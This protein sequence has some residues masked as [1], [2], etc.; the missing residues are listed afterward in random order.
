M[1]TCHNEFVV[2][3]LSDAR[4]KFVKS[5]VH[6]ESREEFEDY[7]RVLENRFYQ[8]VKLP[9]SPYVDANLKEGNAL[10]IYP[11]HGFGSGLEGTAKQG[12]R[13]AETFVDKLLDLD[14]KRRGMAVEKRGTPGKEQPR[15]SLN[16]SGAPGQYASPNYT[17]LNDV[18]P[19]FEASGNHSKLPAQSSNNVY[20][21]NP[22]Q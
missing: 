14:K 5:A 13:Q 7:M 9:K 2:E 22:M 4:E 6:M 20:S 3:Y 16:L 18:T 1:L 15:K 21:L 12:S 8:T 11:P 17:N 19:F 10:P